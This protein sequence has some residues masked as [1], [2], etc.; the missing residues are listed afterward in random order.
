MI[1]ALLVTVTTSKTDAALWPPIP[2]NRGDRKIIV[3]E[4]YRDK[5]EIATNVVWR[6]KAASGK[7]PVLLMP[8]TEFAVFTHHAKQTRH[9]HMIGTE[10][11]TV[12]EGQ[13]TIE[14]EGTLHTLN[15]GDMIIVRPGAFHEVK[16]ETEFLCHVI[17]LNCGGSK[18]RHEQ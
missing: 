13:M 7:C 1:P 6:P 17:T 5:E 14:V 2:P 11:Y 16:R 8:D 18:D 3:T 15:P 9:C 4:V 12:V 10:I